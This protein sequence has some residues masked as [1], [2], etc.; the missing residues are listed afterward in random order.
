VQPRGWKVLTGETI[1]PHD[2]MF[3]SPNGV[4]LSLSVTPVTYNELPTLFAEMSQREREFGVRSD[5]QTLY[6]R[7]NPAARR[8]VKMIKTEALVT[9]FVTNHI[10]HQI[11]CE[12]PQECYEL[13][14]PALLK[15][16]ETYQPLSIT[17]R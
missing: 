5:I 2:I 6:F 15:L 10:A 3:V 16:I 14:R 12:V 7:G 8:E 13:Y 1:A 17:Q 11:F 4:S 9:D